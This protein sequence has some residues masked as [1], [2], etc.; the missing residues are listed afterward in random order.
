MQSEN[1]KMK[2]VL[3]ERILDFGVE[4]IRMVEKIRSNYAGRQIIGQLIRSSTSAGSNY[5]EACGAESRSDFVHKLQI[6]LKELRE[7]L[8]WLQLITKLDLTSAQKVGVLIQEGKE[9]ANMI[10]KSIVTAK[11]NK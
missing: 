3:S 11:R 7:S 1:F 4:I 5:E 9:L 8:Y 10:A 2:N 6:V